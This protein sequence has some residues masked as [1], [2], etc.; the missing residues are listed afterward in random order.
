MRILGVVLMIFAL[1]FINQGVQ[2]L[3]KWQLSI[4]NHIWGI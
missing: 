2:L 4:Q 3:I 1:Y